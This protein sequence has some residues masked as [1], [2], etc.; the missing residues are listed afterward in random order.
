MH[1][2]LLEYLKILWGWPTAI[3]ILFIIFRRHLIKIIGMAERGIEAKIGNVSFKIPPIHVKDE[4][5]ENN[6]KKRRT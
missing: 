1:D 4:R 2:L 3:I 6:I 5:L